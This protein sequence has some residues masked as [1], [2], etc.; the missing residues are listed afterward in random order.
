M[1]EYWSAKK[2]ERLMYLARDAHMLAQH[3]DCAYC[4]MDL[5]GAEENLADA[6]RIVGQLHVALS[7]E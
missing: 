1:A 3:L 7:K 6:K 2:V 5:E 4:L